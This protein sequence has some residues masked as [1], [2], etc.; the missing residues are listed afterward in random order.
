MG[1]SPFCLGGLHFA[2]VDLAMVVPQE[3]RFKKSGFWRFHFAILGVS[4]DVHCLG[5]FLWRWQPS[6]LCS[7]CMWSS[8]SSGIMLVD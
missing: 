5:C 2:I 3:C 1:D 6:I 7:V 4:S 8:Y